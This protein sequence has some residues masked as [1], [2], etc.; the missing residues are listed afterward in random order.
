MAKKEQPKQFIKI[1]NNLPNVKGTPLLINYIET[2][3]CRPR[4]YIPKKPENKSNINVNIVAAGNTVSKSNNNSNNNNNNNQSNKNKPIVNNGN[5]PNAI[6]HPPK[7]F[8]PRKPENQC[9]INVNIVA[10]GNTVSQSN[11]NNRPKMH[12]QT[13]NGHQQNA[14]VNPPRKY[15]PRK[16]DN[17]C[18]VN[19]NIVS[20]G[21]AVPKSNNN[22]KK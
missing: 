13:N 2:N 11:N 6:V 12:P 14:S 9:I 16:P 21:K 19:V 8:I 22:K 4:K 20:A 10:A 3:S 1:N 15:V 18:N 7:R 17:K 5:K